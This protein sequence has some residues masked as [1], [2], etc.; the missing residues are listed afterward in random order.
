MHIMAIAK[1]VTKMK[2]GGDWKIGEFLGV[3]WIRLRTILTDMFGKSLLMDSLPNSK[4]TQ[5]FCF[6]MSLIIAYR[7]SMHI[8]KANSTLP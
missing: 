6:G 8:V 2:A 4:P 3:L 7:H 1:Q 5:L